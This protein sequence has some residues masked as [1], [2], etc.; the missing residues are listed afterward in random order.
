[1]HGVQA[2]G[3]RVA[4]CYAKGLNEKKKKNEGFRNQKKST[5]TSEDKK[6]RGIRLR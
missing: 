2:E 5:F 3:V 4:W 6:K 1:M